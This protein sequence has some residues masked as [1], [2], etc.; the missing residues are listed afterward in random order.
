MPKSY[1]QNAAVK[2]RLH[3]TVSD[4][5]G[6]LN[7][8]PNTATLADNE[9]TVLE[10]MYWKG[11][12]LSGRPGTE[13]HNSVAAN[14]GATCIGLFDYTYAGGGTAEFVG[15]FGT[16]IM[17]DV[18]GTWTN[19]TGA[20]TIT[21]GN[22]NVFT[23]IVFKDV[24]I[25]TN[26]VDVPI[27]W[28]GSGN[29]AVLGGSPPTAPFIAQK[30]GRVFMAGMTSDRGLLRYTQV[31]DHESWNYTTEPNELRIFVAGE[32][33]ITGLV[34][35]RDF[36]LVLSNKKIYSVTANE[37]EGSYLFPFSVDRN[38]PINV[39]VADQRAFV[40][41]GSDA[42]FMSPDG[43]IRSLQ[44][45][46]R[47]GNMEEATLSR[48]INHVTLKNFA[49]S[50]VAESCAAYYSD[51]DWVVFA[52]TVSGGAT[53]AKMVV[54]DLKERSIFLDPIQGRARW[55]PFTGL[56]A[57]AFVTRLVSGKRY[58]YFGDYSGFVRRFNKSLSADAGSAYMKK[59]RTKWFDFGI[60]QVIK[61]ERTMYIETQQG[62]TLSIV[63]YAD[64][65]NTPKQTHTI[66]VVTSAALWG[67]ALWGTDL[68]AANTTIRTKIHPTVRGCVL[69]KEFLN[70]AADETFSLIRYNM[71]VMAIGE[72]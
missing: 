56:A 21:A 4:F 2:E 18:T 47:Y 5:F 26:G 43:R 53:N 49:L 32:E 3:L 8:D 12:S 36:L 59:A 54:L 44:A 10:N 27:K 16:K 1:S 48:P 63:S 37:G 46:E 25:V 15:I 52:Y 62:G 58:L 33:W 42:V 57:N 14:S 72:C 71:G 65:E 31:N 41:L 28:T 61:S 13:K 66:N 64:Y 70:N 23:G 17:K 22:N 19:I 6:G 38:K 39:G 24:L 55:S 11:R 60:P 67:T 51:E 50:R 35:F 20:V 68:W 7:E 9:F 34:D 45:S 40:V 29:A 69:A 30:W